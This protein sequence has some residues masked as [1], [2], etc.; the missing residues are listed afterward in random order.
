MTRLRPSSGTAAL[1]VLSLLLLAG[2]A[3]AQDQRG[4]GNF[5]DNLFSRGEPPAQ[6]RQSAQ[7]APSGRVA[8]S[9]PGDL[10]VRL[11]RMESALRQLTGTI[12]QLQYRNQQLEMQ[13]KRVQDDTEYRFQQLGS[14]GGPAPVPQAAPVGPGNAP[15]VSNPGRRSDVFDPSQNPNAPGAPRTLGN[16]AVIAA[17]EPM[18]DNGTPVG[19]PGGRGAGAP[20][21]LSTVAGNN[22]SPPPQAVAPPSAVASAAAVPVPVPQVAA[23][24]PPPQPQPQP[25]QVRPAVPNSP[26]GPQLATLPP[27]ASPQDEYDMAYGYVLHKDYSLAEQAFR[28][29]LKKY[30]NERLVPEAQYWLGESLFQQQRYRD[31][32]ESFLGVSTKFERAGKAPD[33]LLRLG[34]SLAALNQKEAACATLAE[35]GRKYPRASTGVK[36]G[37]EQEQKRA[38]C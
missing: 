32:A 10:S 35:V 25:Q 2:S 20:L 33:A 30:P 14:R 23:P 6:S 34:Q 12:E 21:D 13:L 19:A 29:F 31:A 5:L 17:P 16:Q 28:D 11:D 7:P 24:S 36:R 1:A 27:S 38:H 18:Q 26:A 3:L 22:N 9:A 15:P 8:Q 4:S 37:V